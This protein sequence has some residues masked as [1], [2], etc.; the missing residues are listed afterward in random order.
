MKP[1]GAE[2]D[3]SGPCVER[4]AEQWPNRRHASPESAELVARAVVIRHLLIE[5]S[6]D[7]R[8]QAQRKMLIDRPFEMQLGAA[9]V[10]GR[11]VGRVERQAK[12]ARDL[13]AGL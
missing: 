3:L 10:I 4:I 8:S 13:E 6:A 1:P 5:V 12:R 7:A 2:V 9:L 11:R